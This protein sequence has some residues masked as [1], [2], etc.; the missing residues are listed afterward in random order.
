MLV[1]LDCGLEIEAD[2][3][4]FNDMRVL[5]LLSDDNPL[6]YPKVVNLVLD[7]KEKEKMYS[8]LKEQN[9]DRIP[10]DKFRDMFTE[11]MQ[12]MGEQNKEVKN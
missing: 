9:N 1:K 2:K 12:K 11:L 7:S 3:E 4:A 10:I 6:G 5:E 8:Y